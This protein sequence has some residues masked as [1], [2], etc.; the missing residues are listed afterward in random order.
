M[1]SSACTRPDRRTVASAGMSS[2][3]LHCCSRPARTL[4]NACPPRCRLVV[5]VWQDASTTVCMKLMTV[6]AQ[7]SYWGRLCILVQ[8]R[9][10]CHATDGLRALHAVRQWLLIPSLWGICPPNRIGLQLQPASRQCHTYPS[11]ICQRHTVQSSRIALHGPCQCLTSTQAACQ[12]RGQ[13]HVQGHPDLPMPAAQH[14]L[15]SSACGGCRVQGT[16]FRGS[17]A[18]QGL[19]HAPRAYQ[20]DAD[21]GLPALGRLQQQAVQAAPRLR[22]PCPSSAPPGR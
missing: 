2:P 10:C 3:A 4:S 13:R 19:A 7:G 18:H 21:A 12:Q 8:E 14:L 9:S 6:H 20:Q 1:R 16:G 22:T 17:G 5:A 11:T 15:G